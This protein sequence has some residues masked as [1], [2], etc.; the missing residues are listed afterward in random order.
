[1]QILSLSIDCGVSKLWRKGIKINGTKSELGAETAILRKT[2]RE[3]VPLYYFSAN[4]QNRNYQIQLNTN[5]G[6][7]NARDV[8][9]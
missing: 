7:F 6:W 1:M 8:Q 3:I 9:K 4:S 5:V 2:T